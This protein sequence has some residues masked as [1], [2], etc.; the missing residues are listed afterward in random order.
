[1]DWELPD[2]EED[3]VSDPLSY[4]AVDS[5]FR[6]NIC[7]FVFAVHT[8]WFRHVV[9]VLAGERAL[10]GFY[11]LGRQLLVVLL[12][13][14]VC[15]HAP[16]TVNC[17]RILTHP[18]FYCRR[19]SGRA[20]IKYSAY[21]PLRNNN[22]DDEDGINGN[23]THSSSGGGNGA[24]GAVFFLHY[25]YLLY[26]L[27]LLI[28]CT[29]GDAEAPPKKISF[30]TRVNNA[31]TRAYDK[32]VASRSKDSKAGKSGASQSSSSK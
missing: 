1:M 15:A 8:A 12:Q 10:R 25:S 3:E 28:C 31:L 27:C 7:R 6:D 24:D 5:E 22:A 21:R 14:T 11:L 9:D 18:C 32:L 4:I 16:A 26:H 20:D 17:L 23:S 2:D 19:S 13:N 30:G 29:P